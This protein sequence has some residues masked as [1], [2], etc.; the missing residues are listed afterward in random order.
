MDLD[1]ITGLDLSTFDTRNVT[2]MAQMFYGLDNITS[3][4][5]SNFNT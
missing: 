1:S 3:L 5:L 2:D 4:D